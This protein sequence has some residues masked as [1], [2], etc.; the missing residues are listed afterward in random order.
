MIAH[1]TDTRQRNTIAHHD[2]SHSSNVNTQI[3]TQDL[4]NLYPP[5]TI[6]VPIDHFHNST[7]YLPHTNDTFSLRYFFDASY[8]KPHGPVIVLQGG[9]TSAVGRLPFLQKGILHDLIVATHGIGVVIEHRYYGESIPTKDFSNENLRF[10]TTEQALA[11]QVYFAKNVVF[12]GLESVDLTSKTTAY[13]TYG[14]SYA[15]GFSA[16]LR[17]LYPD[18][19]WGTLMRNSPTDYTDIRSYRCDCFEWCDTSNLQV[20][21]IL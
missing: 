16:F 21:A 13:L 7:L 19:Y 1:D 17:K 11:D 8:Y 10:L 15:G 14:G 6:S 20:L 5:Q 18:V 4:T 2:T 12:P 3:T 9:E